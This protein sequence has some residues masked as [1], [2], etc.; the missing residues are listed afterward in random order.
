[1]TI[2]QTSGPPLLHQAPGGSNPAGGGRSTPVCWVVSDGKAGT[3]NQALGLAEALGLAPVVKRIRLRAPWRW[4]SPTVRIGNRW[5]VGSG[6]DAFSAPW[7]DLLISAGR[8]GI[9]PSLALRGAAGVFRVHLQD[10][11]IDPTLFDLVVAPA[12][13]G[14]QGPN[15]VSTRGAI[16]RITPARLAAAREEWRATLE[17]LPTP[18]I[19]CLIGG[20]SRHH[21]LPPETAAALGARMAAL[22]ARV[23]GS[24]LVTTSR[25][26]PSDS[27]ARLRRALEGTPHRF[28]DPADAAAGPNPYLGFLAHADAIL[29][30]DDSVSMA[31]DAASTGKPVFVANLPGGAEK[32]ARFHAGLT[33]A[34]ITR[35][36]SDAWATWRYEP[37]ADAALAAEAVRRVWLR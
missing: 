15:V 5:A 31:S 7:P 14:L 28:F 4:L 8:H 1:V 11:R 24:L 32:L 18:R 29:V 19:A 10:P 26:T 22:A 12:H 9:A 36:L 6:G 25:R 27:V 3:E 34:G 13:D 30:T 20:K 17:P 37:L 2:L 33:A 35:P 23:G 21:D 16:N